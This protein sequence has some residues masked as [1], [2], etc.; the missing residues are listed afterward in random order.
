MKHRNQ[1]AV[2]TGACKCLSIEGDELHFDLSRDS[3][4]RASMKFREPEKFAELREAYFEWDRSMPLFPQSASYAR[5]YTE[6][7]MA[8]SEG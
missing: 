8:K 7:T 3:P 6:H 4:E 5:E 1:N 2:R